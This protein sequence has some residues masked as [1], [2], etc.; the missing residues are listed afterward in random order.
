MGQGVRSGNSPDVR[1]RR[2]QT[3]RLPSSKRSTRSSSQ[4]ANSARSESIV[5]AA[6]LLVFGS[7]RKP[8]YS[9]SLFA[10][11]SVG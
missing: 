8:W 2:I 5:A 11:P 10:S 1:F 7:I 6:D 3:R 9:K 4:P